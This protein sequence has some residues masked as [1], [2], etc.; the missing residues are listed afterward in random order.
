VNWILRMAALMGAGAYGVHQLRFVLTPANRASAHAHAYLAPVGTVVVGL[1]LLALAAA[2]ARIARGRVDEAPRLRR[3]WPGT[4]ASLLAVYCV[5][6][7]IERLIAHGES[8]LARGGWVAIPLAVVIGLAVA[9][10]ARGAAAATEV[11]AAER[12]HAPALAIE[13]GPLDALLRPW[14]PRRSRAA[15]R[16]EAA[17]GPPL[18]SV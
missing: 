15:A 16:P 5:Q 6:E 2:L 12:E 17:R 11:A 3:L 13:L 14:S 10:I 8:P 18:A 7:S 4:S 9:L 1:L